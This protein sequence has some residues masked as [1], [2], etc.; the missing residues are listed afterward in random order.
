MRTA[1]HQTRVVVV[2]AYGGGNRDRQGFIDFLDDLD[3]DVVLVNEAD[4]M[5]DHLKSLGRLYSGKSSHGAREVAVVYTGR[6]RAEWSQIKR[7]TKFVSKPF[8]HGRFMA[9]AG[10]RAEVNVAV[11][12]NAV[13]QS[14]RTG[15]WTGNPG[16]KEWRDH[17]APRLKRRLRKVLSNNHPGRKVRVGGDMNAD[18]RGPNEGP[19]PK[20]MFADLGL[21]SKNAGFMWLAWN[22]HAEELIHWRVLG[23][24]PGTDA[25]KVIVADFRD[26]EVVL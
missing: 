18:D 14:G 2:G 5:H 23:K 21:Q 8:A 4:H 12:P 15:K 17:G 11:H 13:I 24:A 10:S 3:P 22:P 6:R 7:L 9:I 26:K 1:K 16:A 20:G 25:H 19:S